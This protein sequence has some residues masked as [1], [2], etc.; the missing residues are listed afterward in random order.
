MSIVHSATRMG[1]GLAVIGWAGLAGWGGGSGPLHLIGPGVARGAVLAAGDPCTL[2]SAGETERFVGPLATPPYRASDGAPDVHGDQCVY[3]GKD[4]RV[5]TVEASWSGGAVAGKAAQDVPNQVGS[6]MEKSGATGM[7]TMAHRVM[8]AEAAGPW[9]RATW[10]PGGSVLATKGDA[11]VIIDVTGL[12][13]QENDALALARIAVPRLAHPLDYDGA[14]A[15]A[16]APKPVAHP[17]HACDF[18]PVSEVVAAIGPLDGA[19]T[20]DSPETTCT[21]RVH[22]AQGERTYEVAYGWQNG[23]KAYASQ[24]HGMATLG[25]LTGLP[26][27]SPLDTMHQ[28]PQVKTMMGVMMKMVGGSSRPGAAA[29]A[30][31][32]TTTVGMRTDTTLVGPWDHAALLHGTQLMAVR[33]D[34]MVAMS[35]QSADYNKAKAL[36]AAICSRL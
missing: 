29:A 36:L 33:H 19:P 8:K 34:V 13:G 20:S 16:L 27:S 4:G 28:S 6:G 22:S 3:R 26:T 9:D 15:V 31:G 5:L 21:Y 1:V 11:T 2:L 32:A 30:P 14:R 10:I 35:L 12:S 24:I 17:A 25:G 23:Q 18:I 7:D